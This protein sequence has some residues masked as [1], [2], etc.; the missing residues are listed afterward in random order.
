MKTIVALYEDIHDARQAV[1]ALVNAAI[2]PED[3]SLIARDVDGRY[4]RYLEVDTAGETSEEAALGAVEGAAGGAVVGGLA[5]LVLGLG[6]LAIPG[7]GPIIA[8]GPIAAGL[9]GAAVG[10]VTGGLLGALVEW[11]VPE[12]E[13]HYYAE[14]LRRGH[15]M[16]AARVNDRDLQTAVTTL[17]LHNPI[18]LQRHAEFWR[19]EE[20][21]RGYDAD[22]RPYT[23]EEISAY[24]RAIN[25]W[26]DAYDGDYDDDLDHDP[27][28]PYEDSFRSH[29][30]TVYG[31]GTYGYDWY[32]P[33]Y[34]FGYELATDRRYWDSDWD[35]V[36]YDAEQ[37]WI[38]RNGGR[39]E[40]F[41]DAIRYAWEEVKDTLGVG[42]YEFGLDDADEHRRYTS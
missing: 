42:T 1:Q 21:W 25:D 28:E 8:A 29:Y 13:A 6:A 26:E 24:R 18:D 38:E 2:A 37:G 3:I 41:K 32:L 20:D 10:A 11:G 14:G 23:A 19:A 34:R 40:E 16:V 33:A 36:A 7:I 27:L 12:E 9:A 5:G 17:N 35:E 15:T 22:A 31:T 39:W 30:R 4:S